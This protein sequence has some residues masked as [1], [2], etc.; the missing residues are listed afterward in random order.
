[1]KKENLFSGIRKFCEKLKS[2][3]ES[4]LTRYNNLS[5]ILK[6]LLKKNIS[7]QNILINN[8]FQFLQYLV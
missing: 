7:N 2:Q 4:T 5:D 1:M 6:V 8:L 3:R